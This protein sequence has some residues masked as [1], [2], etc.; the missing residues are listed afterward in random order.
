M[1][2][3]LSLEEIR[4]NIARFLG[5]R[6]L[7]AC[8]LVSRAWY[9]SSSIF[10]YYDVHL[11][12][13]HRYQ[14]VHLRKSH[15]KR[16]I[17]RQ[18]LQQIGHLVRRLVLDNLIFWKLDDFCTCSRLWSLSINEI[19]L[20]PGQNHTLANYLA[21]HPSLR[22]LRIANLINSPIGSVELLLAILTCPGLTTLHLEYASFPQDSSTWDLFGS[23]CSQ[24]R[25]LTLVQV[26]LPK[27]FA[28]P[29][30]ATFPK[31]E[32]LKIDYHTDYNHCLAIG[33][34]KR[35]PNLR[36]FQLLSNVESTADD[37]INEVI[38]ACPRLEILQ[39]LSPYW[40]RNQRCWLVDSLLRHTGGTIRWIDLPLQSD[41]TCYPEG[42]EFLD[43]L[44]RQSVFEKL[45][46]I[47][48]ENRPWIPSSVVQA[49]LCSCPNLRAIH[50]NS[51]ATADIENGTPWVCLG[52]EFF[53]ISITYED[54]ICDDDTGSFHSRS[55]LSS[56]NTIRHVGSNTGIGKCHLFG[57][58]LAAYE[59][60]A[61]LRHLRFLDTSRHSVIF[62]MRMELKNYLCFRVEYGLEL[63][64]PLKR[65]EYIVF[66]DTFIRT[67]YSDV[68]FMVR[69][70]PNLNYF[71]NHTFNRN[72]EQKIEQLLR[73]H[74]VARDYPF[75]GIF[76][77]LYRPKY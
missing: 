62:S 15:I 69:A 37:L 57:P 1:E 25:S 72:D 55:D 26:S 3:A 35:C 7:L 27:T 58:M 50:A 44:E 51:I 49:I 21:R 65:L 45:E 11:D 67:R 39:F 61:R 53:K 8:A 40:R 52:L 76:D 47:Q 9:S 66:E 32:Q 31:L 54:P 60:L 4:I 22:S 75:L 68:E 64:E 42:I 14:G 18:Q 33:L 77:F 6:D 71:F 74:D 29:N 73:R 24:L 63:L 2:F 48:L 41:E 43:Y 30:D 10:L 17:R 59:Q 46:A 16:N 36:I 20:D 34:P 13:S 5:N 56:R 12:D 38:P 28:W 23:F 19:Y 70:W